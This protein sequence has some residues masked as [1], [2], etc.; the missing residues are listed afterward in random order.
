MDIRRLY[1]GFVI[2]FLLGASAAVLHAQDYRVFVE[3]GV[4][5]L[6]DKHNYNVYGASF[7]STYRTGNNFTAGGEYPIF[8]T[9][10]AEGSYSIFRNNLAVT[11]FIN[12]TTPN[13]EIGYGVRG[14][15]I[16]IDANAHSSKPIK[17]VRPY[18]VVGLDLNRISPTS[19]GS[20]RAQT[21]GFNGV[22]GTV[23]K[24]DNKRGYNFGFG[25]DISLTHML[26][27]R[28]DARDHR[29]ASPTYGLPDTATSA[30]TAYFPIKGTV[31]NLVYSAGIVIHF[32]K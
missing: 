3:G 17:G 2:V 4:S 27:V 12:S 10:S 22:P 26:A 5:T 30:V 9:L 28:L 18:L 29:F 6:H 8:K 20:A 7:G 24:S 25:F 19:G 15:R 31:N 13:D 1:Q 21:P 16:S 32:G 23:L 11:N 14:Q